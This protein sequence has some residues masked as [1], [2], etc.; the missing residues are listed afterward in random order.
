MDKAS[1]LKAKILLLTVITSIVITFSFSTKLYATTEQQVI[2]N[3][4]LPS[5]YISRSVAQF[6]AK[7][8]SSNTL[9]TTAIAESPKTLGKTRT[10]H[11]LA[12]KKIGKALSRQKNS[13]QIK[14]NT[15]NASARVASY[16]INLNNFTIYRAFSYLLDDIDG[17]E[18]FRSFSVVF[19][20]DIYQSSYAEV[21]AELY[22]RQNGGPWIHYYSSDIFSLYGESEDDEFE[23]T[24]TLEQGYVSGFYDVLID[25]YE[26]NSDELV[27]SYSSDDTSTLYGLTLESSDYDQPYVPEV[28]VIYS[29]GGSTSL[30]VLVIG[31]FMALF[32]VKVCS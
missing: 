24:T 7:K 31:F 2:I 17:D 13:I 12:K 27:A 5:P 3:K 11:L 20:A 15:D 25:L 14:S 21:Y 10:E 22:L 6:T 29:D 1:T 28:E 4:E 23:V 32:R 26:V 8:D 19:D 30:F 18:F 16:S 9:V